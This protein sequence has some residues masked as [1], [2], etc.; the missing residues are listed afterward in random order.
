MIIR[1]RA[2]VQERDAIAR[3]V[4]ATIEAEGDTA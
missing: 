3:R 1:L 2:A 4:L